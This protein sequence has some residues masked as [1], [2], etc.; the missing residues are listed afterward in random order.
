[1]KRKIESRLENWI[2]TS[3]K[4]LLVTGARQVGKTWIIREVLSRSKYSYFEINFIAS[5]NMVEMLGGNVTQDDFLLR[6]KAILP[7][8]CEVHN[9]IIFFDEVQECPELI[10]RIKFLVDEGS[11][12]YVLSGSLLGITLKGMTSAPV[13][14]LT[15]ETMF[16]MDFEEFM[17]ANRISEAVLSHLVQCYEEKKPVDS[18]IHEKLLSL[19]YVYLIVGGMPDAVNS[20]LESKDIR[21]VSQ[22][23]RD[24]IELYKLDFTKYEQLDK[25]LKLL[26]IYD[27]VP[28]ELNKQNKRFIFTYL[29]KELKF[30]RYENSFLWLKDAGVVIPVYNAS[31]PKVPLVSSKSS[32]L[33][34]LYYNDIGLLTSSYTNQVQI[35]LLKHNGAVNCGSIFENAVAQQLI[36][37]GL[38]PYFYKR[39]DIGEIDFLIEKDGEIILVEVKSGKDTHQ[40]KALDALM[41]NKG[42]N[43]KG[44]YV[45]SPDNLEVRGSVTYIPCYMV[46]FIKNEE[47]VYLSLEINLDNLKE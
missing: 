11:F 17:W 42:F 28:S 32:N 4:A 41:C 1:M 14:Y 47:P 22:T 35:E 7:A 9:T 40:H 2:E 38:N 26:S 16:P 45:I 37:N 5:P 31:L 15:I 34:K 3:K 29:N 43:L 36:A 44:A 8:K 46:C 23:Q 39:K 13:G 24:I 20:Y 30:D 21:R 33:F 6:L 12:R 18:L 25:R 27:L 19:F 10:T